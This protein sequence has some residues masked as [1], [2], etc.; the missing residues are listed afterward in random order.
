MTFEMTSRVTIDVPTDNL[1]SDTTGANVEVS[2][3]R[4]VDALEDAINAAFPLIDCYVNSISSGLISISGTSTLDQYDDMLARVS[5][6]MEQ[7]WQTG[8]W[9]VAE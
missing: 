6:I 5:E 1:F 8:D 2:Q 9:I 4:F 3:Q 7:V